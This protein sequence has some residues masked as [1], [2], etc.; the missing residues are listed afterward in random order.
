MEIEKKKIRTLVLLIL[1]L[2]ISITAVLAVFRIFQAASKEREMSRLKMEMVSE[3]LNNSEERL[4]I[5]KD[6]FRQN[7]DVN[8]VLICYTLKPPRCHLSLFGHSRLAF[9]CKPAPEPRWNSPV[10]DCTP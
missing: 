8:V 6:W 10:N 4:R 7:I 9:E 3:M 1:V 2:V 5:S